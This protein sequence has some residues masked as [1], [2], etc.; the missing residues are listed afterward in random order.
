MQIKTVHQLQNILD[1]TT[2]A[3]KFAW[4]HAFVLIVF[5][6]L[7][8]DF[9]KYQ[10]V[11]LGIFFIELLFAIIID[12]SKMAPNRVKKDF[13][14]PMHP[15]NSFTPGTIAYEINPFAIGSTAYR[16]RTY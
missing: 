2:K 10:N 11:D 7:I 6:M 5:G 13:I 8:T 16:N 4:R 3:V 1:K 14:T 15:S 9:V 12:K